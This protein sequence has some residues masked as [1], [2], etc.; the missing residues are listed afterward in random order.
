MRVLVADDQDFI[1]R[2]LR[3]L[4]AGEPDIQVCGEANNGDAAV[5]MVQMLLPDVMIM[6][7]SMPVLDGLQATLV[8]REFFPKVQVVTA[9]QYELTDLGEALLVGARAHVPKVAVSERLIPTLRDLPLE[10]T[11][12]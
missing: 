5:R 9:S 6:D 2:A 8:I 7:I 10:E 11:I 4:L 1:R 12:N 3:K